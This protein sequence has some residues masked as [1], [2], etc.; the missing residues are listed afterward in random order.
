MNHRAILV[1]LPMLKLIC[2]R[3][4]WLKNTRVILSH[5]LTTYKYLDQSNY[6][7]AITGIWNYRD[8]KP[9]IEKN[10]QKRLV[11]PE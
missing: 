9:V 2:M 7:K 6:S 11:S 3:T 10:A 4:I 1:V 8:L 5:Q